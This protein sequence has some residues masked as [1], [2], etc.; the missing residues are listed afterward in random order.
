VTVRRASHAPHT[1]GE[2]GFIQ[3]KRERIRTFAAEEAEE[4]E[5]AGAQPVVLPFSSLPVKNCPPVLL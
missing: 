3:R 5:K 4:A 2:I 1:T